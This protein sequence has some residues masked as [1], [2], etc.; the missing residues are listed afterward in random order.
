MARPHGTKYIE[1]PILLLELFNKYVEET[2]S[3]PFIIKDWVGGIGKEVLREK[4]KPL[5]IEGFSVYCYNTIGCVKQYFNNTDDRYND[6]IA[7]CSHI[8][9]LIRLDQISGGMAGIY[10]PSITQ[11]LNSLVEKTENT[12]IEQ[13]LFIDVPKNDGNK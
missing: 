4:E 9:E 6:Y 2:K 7:I 1:T 13:P 11:R 3:K 5:T 8:K 12:N 10:N